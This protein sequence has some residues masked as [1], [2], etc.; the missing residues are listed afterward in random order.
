MQDPKQNLGM[1]A[2]FHY[3]KTHP[4]QQHASWTTATEYVPAAWEQQPKPEFKPS[5]WWQRLDSNQPHTDFQSA[6]LPDEL[7][8]L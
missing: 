2:L 1:E 8:R 7:R 4:Y 6:A 3:A 5:Y